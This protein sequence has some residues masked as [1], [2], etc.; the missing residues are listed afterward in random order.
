M[1]VPAVSIPRRRALMGRYALWQAGDFVIN[2]GIITIILF[3]LLG[4]IAIMQIRLNEQYFIA[5]HRT[6]PLAGRLGPFLEVFAMFT[7]VGPIIAMSGVVSQDR[8]SGY[9]RFLF[10]KPVSPRAFYLQS[11]AV[12]MIGYLVVGHILVLA[13]SFYQPPSYTVRFVADMLLSFISVGGI[14]FLFSVASRYDGLLLVV[15]LLLGSIVRDSWEKAAG[16]K[17]AVT[18]LFPP[19]NHVGDLHHWV[20]GVNG[21]G[22]MAAVEFP[23]KWVWWNAGYGLACGILGLYLLRK[24]PLTKA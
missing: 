13:Y 12:R 23:A 1:T 16:I 10:A 22:S 21:V 11:V 8:T 3:G 15:F 24:V 17:H 5:S 9:T 18:F 14:L 20:V 19:V 4:V 7:M 2:V 6:M